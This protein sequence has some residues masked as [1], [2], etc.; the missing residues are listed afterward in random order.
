MNVINSRESR[1]FLSKAFPMCF[2]LVTDTV[3]SISNPAALEKPWVGEFVLILTLC[4]RL[5]S[6]AFLAATLASQFGFPQ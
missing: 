1:L 3:A 6:Y 5:T 4:I 2:S